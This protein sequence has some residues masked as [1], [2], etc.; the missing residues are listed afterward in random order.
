MHFFIICVI[1]VCVF[2]FNAKY[3]VILFHKNCCF[4]ISLQL[5]EYQGTE[6]HTEELICMNKLHVSFEMK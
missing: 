6:R 4:I 2:N 5:F 3:K 1:V